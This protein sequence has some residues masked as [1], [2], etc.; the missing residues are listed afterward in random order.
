M[1]Y[2]QLVQNLAA[3]S[4]VAVFLA[5]LLEG[6]GIPLP[7]LTFALVMAALAGQGQLNFWLVYILTVAGGVIGGLLGYWIGLKGGRKL[8]EKYGRYMLITPERFAKAE[9]LFQKHG[10]KAIFFGRYLPA[11]CVW[12][13]NLSGIARFP[14]VR[15]FIS[16]LLGMILWS[17]T[18]LTLGYV[19]GR[20]FET[21]VQLMN[22]FVL[23][24]VGGL[25]VGGILIYYYNR[26]RSQSR[27]QAAPLAVRVEEEEAA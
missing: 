13:S 20:S 15:F 16:N 27:L 2:E 1:Q 6:V 7:S 23:L 10:T 19:G 14:F 11:I 4:Y 5:V 26:R 12:G 24:I 3:W 9:A 8:V 18:Q 21:L 17:T 25:L 22:G